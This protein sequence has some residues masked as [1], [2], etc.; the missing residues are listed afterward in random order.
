MPVILGID[1]SC[2]DTAVA[3]YSQ[4]KGVLFNSVSSQ[5]ELHS[6]YGGIV[7][8]LAAREHIKNIPIIFK[9]LKENNSELYEN[10]DAIAVTFGPGLVGSL[11][12]GLSFAKAL[13][14]SLN[15]PFIPI[16]HLEGHI[17]STLTGRNYPEPPGIALIVS[18]GHTLLC[19][20]IEEGNYRILGETRDDACGE[21]FDK[22][23]KALGLS[24]PG[25]PAIEKLAERADN[26]VDFPV[27]MEKHSSLDFSFSGLK[28]AVINH[29]KEI[30]T[31]DIKE[32]E[33]SNIAEG[34]QRSAFK[35]LIIKTEETLKLN[36]YNFLIVS[37][38]VIANK[39]LREMISNL[40]EEVGEIIIPDIEYATDNAVMIARC[41]LFHYH[42]KN[43]G[44]YDMEAY[45]GINLGETPYRIFRSF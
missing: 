41:G 43:Y 5:E 35:E 30:D 23:A 29:L 24:Y 45:P 38:G 1:T 9:N 11:L 42:S 21:A 14:Y 10:L 33:I 25:G 37:G 7:P 22:V 40:E 12:T 36:E 26:P 15:I 31:D 19:E 13:S 39:Q 8:E 34:F 32:D 4:E 2:D 27:P 28:T 16:N 44:K 6:I 17:Y 18:G 3:V 20:V